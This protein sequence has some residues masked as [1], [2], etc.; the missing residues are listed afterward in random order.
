MR[1]RGLVSLY[2]TTNVILH[3]IPVNEYSPQFTHVKS[4]T[5][6]IKEN[7]EC[8]R[9]GLLLIDLNATDADYGVQGKIKYYV[10]LGGGGGCK[11]PWQIHY[12]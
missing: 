8:G 9:E 1:D 10:D 11:C 6:R 7:Q 4:A 2:N 12:H 5:F 3:I